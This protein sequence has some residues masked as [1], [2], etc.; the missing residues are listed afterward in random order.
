MNINEKNKGPSPD[1]SLKN[2]KIAELIEN[3][4][5]YTQARRYTMHLDGMS[6]Q[7]IAK[8]EGVTVG[9][10]QDSVNQAKFKLQNDSAEKANRNESTTAG[11]RCDK[12]TEEIRK[13]IGAHIKEYNNIPPDKISD[14]V[15]LVLAYWHISMLKH[16][17]RKEAIKQTDYT[18][19]LIARQVDFS[20]LPDDYSFPD[21]DK[22]EHDELISELDKLLAKSGLS[23]TEKE[24]LFAILTEGPMTEQEISDKTGTRGDDTRQTIIGLQKKG[25]VSLKRPR[26]RGGRVSKEWKV[27]PTADMREM[28]QM[29][30][31]MCGI[32]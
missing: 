23:N 2:P 6:Y 19:D 26:T 14:E 4:L 28:M 20:G 11:E 29:I 22:E 32:R 31:D 30:K 3:E 12:L 25:L 15:C 21:I 5:T 18:I 7:N 17:S 13:V 10:V 8:A 16:M 9:A 24:I 27:C 1:Y